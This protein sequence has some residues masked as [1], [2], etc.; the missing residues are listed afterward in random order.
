MIQDAFYSINLL[1]ILEYESDLERL[2]RAEECELS[3]AVK[4][5]VG[6]E[7]TLPPRATAVTI[8]QYGPYSQNKTLVL[9]AAAFIAT[10]TDVDHPKSALKDTRIVF[11]A[12]ESATSYAR[13]HQKNALTTRSVACS[14][15]PNEH[16]G[17]GELCLSWAE[18]ISDTD[19]SSW[20]LRS[21]FVTLDYKQTVDEYVREICSKAT[22][23]WSA[24]GVV[25]KSR[26]IGTYLELGAE[27]AYID[28]AV[29]C[30]KTFQNLVNSEITVR[31]S[32]FVK[33]NPDFCGALDF[34]R[35]FVKLVHKKLAFNDP[36]VF[37]GLLLHQA[38][39]DTEVMEF[40]ERV[41]KEALEKDPSVFA[42]GLRDP[43]SAD[44]V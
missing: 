24:S 6:V 43:Q 8:L 30:S 18:P 39:Y 20:R 10:N 19:A 36:R 44:E 38:G 2:V 34:S 40:Y 21:E 5:K 12:D 33:E 17:G 4:T 28:A 29:S 41:R 26:L 22:Q 1:T 32:H 23:L 9:D 15:T 25:P 16:S 27:G 37:H 7:G 3:H 31:K 14:S 42:I 11:L 13:G 35:I